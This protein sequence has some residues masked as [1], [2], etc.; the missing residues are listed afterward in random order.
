[1]SG[2]ASSA[3]QVPPESK[4]PQQPQQ[5]ADPPTQP[6]PL[7][8]LPVPHAIPHFT[9]SALPRQVR[10]FAP[11]FSQATPS[12]RL[13]HPSDQVHA[14]SVPR[15]DEAEECGAARLHALHARLAAMA[16]TIITPCGEGAPGER[17]GTAAASLQM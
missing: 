8:S 16:T 13:F 17:V 9:T 2:D 3:V 15:V 7:R 12:P 10:S 6:S 11:P 5:P 4:P 14:Q 1:M